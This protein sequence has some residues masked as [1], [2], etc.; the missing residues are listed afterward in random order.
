MKKLKIDKIPAWISGG[1]VLFLSSACLFAVGFS[2]WTFAG[3][4]N[5]QGNLQVDAD[6]LVTL[7]TEFL[8]MEPFTYYKGGTIK[9]GLPSKK[10]DIFFQF[11]LIGVKRYIQ[12]SNADYIPLFL[13]LD[14]TGSFNLLEYSD[15][16]PQFSFSGSAYITQSAVS[17]DVS[18]FVTSVFTENKGTLK[19]ENAVHCI[20]QTDYIYGSVVY[21]FDFTNVANFETDIYNHMSEVS[22]RFSLEVAE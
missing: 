13:K 11:R 7:Q 16:R 19:F 22:F 6:D 3:D 17:S 8:D 10:G 1:G 21:H 4:T 12:S 2:A 20:S 15:T 14:T 5:G 9:N 18:N